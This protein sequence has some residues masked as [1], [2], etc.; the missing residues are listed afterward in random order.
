[1]FASSEV[2][3]VPSS[4]AV[5]ALRHVVESSASDELVN[6]LEQQEVWQKVQ[7]DEKYWQ[8]YIL[9]ARLVLASCG[10]LIYRVLTACSL[11]RKV[12]F[13]APWVCGFFVCVWNISGTAEQICAKFTWKTCLVLCSDDFEGQR[14]GSASKVRVSRD[15]NGFFGPFGSLRAVCVW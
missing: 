10:F 8:G 1:M 7:D 9:L 2:K 14:S 11:L 13:L 5:D 4:V 3:V 12:L 15:K 6:A